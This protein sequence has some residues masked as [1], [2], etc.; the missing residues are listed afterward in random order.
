MDKNINNEQLNKSFSNLIKNEFYKS[1]KFDEE[2]DKYINNLIYRICYDYKLFPI[3]YVDCSSPAMIIENNLPTKNFNENQFI[4]A[5]NSNQSEIYDS[6]FNENEIINFQDDY[7]LSDKEDFFDS[8]D[9]I[10]D[11]STGEDIQKEEESAIAKIYVELKNIN[12][13]KSDSLVLFNKFIDYL[14]NK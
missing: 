11:A 13:S 6:R 12:I 5:E 10:T 2:K 14:R 1:K 8:L 3:D 4:P 9:S 7:N